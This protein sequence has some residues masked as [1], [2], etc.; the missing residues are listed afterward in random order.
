[1]THVCPMFP[2]NNIWNS[3]VDRQPVDARSQDYIR[4]IGPDAPLHPDFGWAGGIAYVVTEGTDPPVNLGWGHGAPNSDPGPYRIPENAP[5]ETP[6][7]GHVL[8]LNT[9]ECLLYE[10]FGAVHRSPGD[11]TV[12]SSAIFDL[13]SNRLRPDGWT[14][15][16][17]AGL[18]MLPG[19]VR[20]DEVA[21]GEVRH[22]VRF[23]CRQTRR[24]YVWPARHFASYSND[25]NLPPMGQRF[26]LRASFDIR[27]FSSQARVILAA[28]QKYGMML[29]DN[30]GNWYI[31][32]AP[33]SR[34]PGGL[35]SEFRQVHGSDFEA[36]DVS[37]LMIDA[38]T[39][40]V[41]Q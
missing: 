23:T 3:P 13:R 8:V 16:D 25:P 24:A 22:A 2:A 38:G 9:R 36:V 35:T 33:D 41:R 30:G 28:L 27:G 40:E 12:D 1:M 5:I 32:G 29:S 7:D 37:S 6:G 15:A 20:Y 14:S 31:T 21:S 26:R 39:G 18:P 4:T 19:L 10:L 17:G 11:W 34:W